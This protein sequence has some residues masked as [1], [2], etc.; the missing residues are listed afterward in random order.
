MIEDGTS[1]AA[2]TE[3]SADICI[4]GSC[5]AGITLAVKLLRT[6][7]RILVLESAAHDLPGRMRTTSAM[8]PDTRL[9]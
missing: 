5:A 1:L 8:I 2:G 6:G 9:N 4:I 7:K 3:V